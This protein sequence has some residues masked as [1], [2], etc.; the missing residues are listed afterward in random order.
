MRILRAV[1][2]KNT[3]DFQ[4]HPDTYQAIKKYVHLIENISKER[5]ADELNKMII[6]QKPGQAFEEL[7]EIGALEFL[8]P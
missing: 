3:F 5:I 7:F 4:Y 6:S 1:R 2:F 8:I